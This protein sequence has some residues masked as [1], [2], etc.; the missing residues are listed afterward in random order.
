[1][2][3][4]E[5]GRVGRR[6]VEGRFDG[7]SVT[8]DGGVMLL[9]AVDCKLGLLEAA[10]RCIA[11]PRRVPMEHQW[12]RSLRTTWQAWMA[13][14]RPTVQREPRPRDVRQAPLGEMSAGPIGR[15]ACAAREQFGAAL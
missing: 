3:T 9:G 12:T 13:S 6:V 8:S 10:P 7:G 2:G 4:I 5:F 15:P 11:D 14:A 1:V